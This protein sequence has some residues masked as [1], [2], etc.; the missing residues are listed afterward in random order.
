MEKNYK[1]T[2]YTICIAITLSSIDF[3]PSLLCNVKFS[4]YKHDVYEV[5]PLLVTTTAALFCYCYD[6]GEQVPV[7]IGIVVA[8]IKLQKKHEHPITLKNN[9]LILVVGG[10]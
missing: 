5:Y 8:P 10:L 7:G 1:I 2:D 4:I 3:A 9:I 6:C